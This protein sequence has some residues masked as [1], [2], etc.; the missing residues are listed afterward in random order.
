MD[1]K[2]SLKVCF[3]VAIEAIF[4]FTPL[5]SIPIGPIVAT[6][7]MI[8]VIIAS[9]TFGKNIGMLLGFVIHFQSLLDI[10]VI[11]LVSLFVLY[12]EF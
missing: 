1:L 12:L 9:L 5:G 11:F 2:L 3:L 10:K 8:P 6:L 4:C 7:A